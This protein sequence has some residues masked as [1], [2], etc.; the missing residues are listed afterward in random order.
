MWTPLLAFLASLHHNRWSK[1]EKILEYTAYFNAE[2][3]VRGSSQPH[4]LQ[5]ARQKTRAASANFMTT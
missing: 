1:P 5:P 2:R 3:Q 4:R